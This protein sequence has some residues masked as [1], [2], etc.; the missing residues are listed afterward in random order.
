MRLFFGCRAS[1]K[2]LAGATLIVATVGGQ[3]LAGLTIQQGFAIG[4]NGLNGAPSF[5]GWVSNTITGLSGGFVDVGNFSTD[6]TAFHLVTSTSV[7]DV[8]PTADFNSWRGNASPTGAFASEWGNLLYSPVVINCGWTQFSLSQVVFSGFSSDNP[9]DPD[10]S[11]LGTTLD[12]KNF[13]YNAGASRRAPPR[14]RRGHVR[15]QRR[16]QPA[17]RRTDLSRRRSLRRSTRAGRVGQGRAATHQSRDPSP[18]R[19][20][21]PDF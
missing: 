3:A 7:R 19:F 20:R 5:P 16:F 6:P 1:F 2:A 12:L 17:C 13:S 4:P 14:R 9:G 11:L 21:R 8:I 10:N 18:F 15:H